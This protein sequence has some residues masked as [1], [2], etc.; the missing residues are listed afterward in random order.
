MNERSLFLAALDIADPSE[1]SAYLDRACAG[2]AA[3]RAQV[4]QLLKAHQA[5]GSFMQHPAIALGATVDDP[6]RER[7]GTVIGP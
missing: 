3:L 5:S 1:R 4:E 7:P 2:D 6:I